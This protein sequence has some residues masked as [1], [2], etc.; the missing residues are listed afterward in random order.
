MAPDAEHWE[1]PFCET[2]SKS[3]EAETSLTMKME[4]K[5]IGAEV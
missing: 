3:M 5:E 4:R 1:L 2:L